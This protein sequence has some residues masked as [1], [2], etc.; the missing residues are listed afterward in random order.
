MYVG[1]AERE[2]ASEREREREREREEKK[3]RRSADAT[4]AGFYIRKPTQAAALDVA[5]H[6][7]RPRRRRKISRMGTWSRRHK[8]G[9][10]R[11]AGQEGQ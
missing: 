11:G 4:L 2:R 1:A 7:R 3:Y 8:M 10:W 9:D 5:K 6:Q